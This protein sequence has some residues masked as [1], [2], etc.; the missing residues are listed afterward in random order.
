MTSWLSSI[1]NKVISLSIL[2]LNAFRVFLKSMGHSKMPDD[3][4]YLFQ[5]FEGTDPICR[6]ASLI[7]KDIASTGVVNLQF[8]I[9]LSNYIKTKG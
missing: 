9:I 3:K 7:N 5:L 8:W 6:T 4:S 1:E 2:F